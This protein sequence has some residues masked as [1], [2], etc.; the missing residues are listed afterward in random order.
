MKRKSIKS[1]APRFANLP[2][3]LTF[4]FS[5]S[6]V[7]ITLNPRSPF[8]WI[9]RTTNRTVLGGNA[10]ERMLRRIQVQV[11]WMFCG[12]VLQSL[13]TSRLQSFK[14]SNDS[15]PFTESSV[16]DCVNVAI[17]P[18]SADSEPN[19]STVTIL[20]CNFPNGPRGSNRRGGIG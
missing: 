1:N 6:G 2:N 19:A 5:Y 14:A 15:S 12:F 3:L 9:F 13:F 18:P 11:R 16:A 10:C 4:V 8:L 20:G 7:A 17:K